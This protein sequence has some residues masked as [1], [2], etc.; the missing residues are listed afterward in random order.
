VP[1]A[2]IGFLGLIRGDRMASIT[3]AYTLAFFDRHLKGEP[4]DLLKG[5]SPDYPEVSLEVRNP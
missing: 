1:A 3:S 2:L 5:N 4:A